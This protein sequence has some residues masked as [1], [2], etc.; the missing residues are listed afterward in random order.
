MRDL[1]AQVTSSLLSFPEVTIDALG[2]DEVTLDSVLHGRFTVGKSGLA[3]LACGPQLEVVHAV[4]GER[5]S[6]YRFSGVSEHPPTV[7]AMRDFCW[8]KRT[9]LLVGLE[10]GE[11]SMLCLYDLGISRVVKAVVIPG[12]ITAIEPLVSYGGA[13]ASTQHLHQSLRWFFGVAAVVTDVGHVLLVDLC[14]DDL[15]CSQSEL[16]A[17]DL[18]V[19]NKSPS[20]IPRFRE[21]A[22]QQ[23]RHLCLQLSS[24]TDTG[25]TALQYIQRTNQLAVGFADGYLQL[26]NM[27]T[28]KKEYHSRLEGGRVPVYAFTF[29]E[30]ENDPR[31]CCY[32]WAVQSAQDHEGDVVSLHLLQLAFGERKCLAS[33]KII[34]EGLEYCDERYSQ[35]LNGTAFPLRAQ[36]TNTR[37]IGCQTIEKFRHHPDRDDSMNEAA[38]P[39]TSVSIF[40]W[41]VKSYGQGQ[42]STFIGVFDINRWYHAQMP[43]SLRTGE[44]LRNC[45]YL[46]VWS[47]DSV[48]EM[49]ASCPLMDLIVHERS[50]SRGLPYTCPPPEQFFN[51]TTY[52]FDGSCLLNTGIVHFTCSGHQKETLSYLKKLAPSL[53]DSITNGYSRCLMSGLLSSRLADVQPSSLSQEE[54][55]DAILCT[56]VETSSLGFITGCI[57]QWTTEEQAGAAVNLR[58]ILEWAWNKVVRT[59]EELDEICAPLF[60]SFT[61]FTDP[62]TLQLLQ[63]SQRLLANLSTIFH[64]LLNDAQELTQ[65]GLVGLM[66]KC[67]VSSLISQYAQ[68]VLWF[69]RT[70]L[71]PE[72]TDDDVLQISR[73]F[74]SHSIIKNYYVSQREEL[75]RLAKDKW[76]ADCLLID[77]LV[78]QCG[79]RLVELWRRDEGGTGQYPPPTLH[80][81]LDIYLLENVEESAKHAIVIYLLLDVMYSFP[82][83]SG[84]SVESFPTAFGIPIG[85]VKL[86][87]GLWLLDHHDHESSLELLLHPAT[88]H[89]L[90]SWQHERV[91]QALMCQ[92]KHTLALRYLHVMKPPLCT[93]SQAKLSLS[94]LL[95]N[96]C[97]VEAWA[98]LRQHCNKLNMEEL[99]KFLFD[100]CQELGLM[101]ELLN[102]PLGM[103]EQECLERFLQNSGGFQNREL[104]M[105]HYLQQAN[106]VPA[107]QLNQT[108]KVNLAA[109]RDPK[110][111]ERSNTRNSILNQYGKVLPRVQR[112][113][114]IERAKPYQHPATIH[115]E[116]KRPQPLSTVAKRSASENVMTRAAFINNVLSKIEEVWV[117]KNPT[118]ESSPSK[119]PRESEMQVPSLHPPSP[120]LPE[121][122]VGTPINML[123][124]RMS[125]LLD[126]VVQPSSQTSPESS[127]LPGTPSRSINSWA[128]PKSISKAPELNLL[129]T[130][131]V[132]KRA[133]ALASGPVYSAFTPQSILRTSLRPTPVATPSASPGRSISPTLRHKESR[134]TFIEDA[135]SPEAPKGSVHWN[136][137]IAFN[138]EINTPKR[139]SPPP[140]ANIEVWSEHSDLEEEDKHLRTHTPLLE[141]GENLDVQSECGSSVRGI[142][143]E[144]SK[145]V[146]PTLVSR[147]S[148]G[149]EASF[150]SNQSDSTLEFHDAPLPE[151]FME[152]QKKHRAVD[153]FDHEVTVNLPSSDKDLSLVE[154]HEREELPSIATPEK[155]LEN[156]PRGL[157]ISNTEESQSLELELPVNVENNLEK[158]VTEEHSQIDIHV[159]VIESEHLLQVHKPSDSLEGLAEVSVH[160]D[161]QELRDAE[162]SVDESSIV[163]EAANVKPVEEYA[164]PSTSEEP[165]GKEEEPVAQETDTVYTPTIGEPKN[166]EECEEESMETSDLD[167]FVEQHLFGP[168]LSPPLTRTSIKETPEALV[169]RE[170]V[171]DVEEVQ[172][173]PENVADLKTQTSVT[174]SEPATSESRSVV[175]LNDSDEL[176]SAESEDES[177]DEGESGDENVEDSG[178]EVEIIEEVKGNGRSNHQSSPVLFLEEV[179]PHEQYLQEQADAVLSLVT[180][181]EQ[182]KVLDSGMPV[183]DGE[184]VMVG[185]APADVDEEDAVSYTELK[186]STT[187]LVPVELAEEPQR[188]LTLQTLSSAPDEAPPEDCGNFTL[189][190]DPDVEEMPNT[191]ELDSHN[192][193]IPLREQGQPKDNQLNSELGTSEQTVDAPED[194][195]PEIE[196]VEEH[197]TV[198]EP[199]DVHSDQMVEPTSTSESFLQETKELSNGDVLDSGPF[200]ILEESHTSAYVKVLELSPPE[201]V[202]ISNELLE[203]GNEVAALHA[204]ENITGSSQ[205]DSAPSLEEEAEKRSPIKE[206]AKSPARSNSPARSKVDRSAK[207]SMEV[208]E[209]LKEMTRSPSR[210][211]RKTVTFPVLSL[212]AEEEQ[213]DSEVPSTPRRVT[214]SGKQLQDT[215]VPVTPRSTRKAHVEQLGNDVDQDMPSAKVSKPTSSAQKTPQKATPRKGSRRTR[216]TAVEEE[217]PVST[218]PSNDPQPQTRQSARKA[219]QTIVEVPETQQV[220]LEEK[221]SQARSSPSRVTRKSTRGLALESFQE[222]PP[223]DTVTVNRPLK[224][225]PRSRKKTTIST[226]EKANNATF[227]IDDAKL[228]SVSRRLT[229]S[230]HW[231]QIDGSEREKD[232]VRLQVETEYPQADALAE[233]LDEQ[234]RE[235]S[236]PVVTE[237]IRAKRRTTKSVVPAS[238]LNE[239]QNVGVEESKLAGSDEIQEPANKSTRR[240]RGRKVSEQNTSS[241]ADS[242][243]STADLRKTRGRRKGTSVQNETEVAE[244]LV[245]QMQSSEDAVNSHPKEDNGSVDDAVETEAVKPKK[246]RTTRTKA[247]PEPPPPV[248]I[249][250]LSP[251]A[252]PAEPKARTEKST[253]VK[254][255]PLLKMNL[256]RKRMMDAIFPKPVTR[257][258]KL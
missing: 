196:P 70:G 4:T 84:A 186:P 45:P 184:V 80:A 118:P 151:D 105:V 174:S 205:V 88:S 75:Q 164:A 102:L 208:S 15:S 30:P 103:A 185:L 223:E 60:D 143:A 249:S 62:Q 231:N 180:P 42:P 250:F 152:T 12:K 148:L 123:T 63:H 147:P 150:V 11:G 74:Y 179:P 233:R 157:S 115:R 89:S 156:L 6:A 230:Q 258:K 252:S 161:I 162:E 232:M 246:K 189:V 31:N 21:G 187:L 137:G 177:E 204:N 175:T 154:I 87:Q 245:P 136:N 86:V 55:L 33:G 85:L 64:C 98:L 240:T 237:I 116:V 110:M 248:E 50:L 229:R 48:V 178:S 159:Q 106:Y 133:R 28:L 239:T 46:A 19:V 17:S 236:A 163:L 127:N 29:Q 206:L 158:E 1:A 141:E 3:W 209:T 125:R 135:D 197:K 13:S 211:G 95:H 199:A 221:S 82:N 99:M 140:K 7:L 112:K 32:L 73:P 59:K 51:P 121:P 37:L 68:V 226:T 247:A 181:E 188:H 58:Y 22:I 256:R 251:L 8:L 173:V 131:Q 218:D 26:W 217:E 91:L 210:R 38:S 244:T 93:T 253:D 227:V 222:E 169:Q 65:K 160:S 149:Q 142:P 242:G 49:T 24:P 144:L 72:G 172:P 168:D 170:P 120:N 214:R 167:A 9:G 78:T 126:L 225:P 139:S 25:A 203:N 219:R 201:N 5:F 128:G 155:E 119:C 254:D 57:K 66:N 47:L 193:L 153:S 200:E 76:C 134:I 220:V 18:E 213:M 145:Q 108:L 96:R 41:Q 44:S 207:S 39:D 104:L 190:L 176:T 100:T 71:L 132:V 53:G 20:E 191:L 2:E 183:G 182:L 69:C 165:V 192:D 241:V 23:G 124:K 234:V 40:S 117:G 10:E 212:D 194:L 27:K 94:V 238:T 138:R 67:M 235:E 228:Q 111:K 166:S 215:P 114:A 130:P 34:Y 83:K 43:D 77:G 216:S 36:A 52:N 35:D 79:E 257:R 224:T 195:E 129:Q 198:E 171:C 16:E 113:L 101:K 81:L 54:Q 255:T 92:Q 97:I 61:N 107:L 14:L 90:W 56:A 109:D 243:T 122:F 202:L 146:L